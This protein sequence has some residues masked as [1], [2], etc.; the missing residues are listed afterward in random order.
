[1]S[2][3]L[4]KYLQ[5]AEQCRALELNYFDD[6]TRSTSVEPMSEDAEQI[7]DSPSYNL[8]SAKQMCMEETVS[9]V[10]IPESLEIDMGCTLCCPS[11]PC[12]DTDQKHPQSPSP[13]S[14]E[15]DTDA[16]Q[17]DEEHQVEDVAREPT[18]IHSDQLLTVLFPIDDIITPT[19]KVGCTLDTSHL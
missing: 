3:G 1:M 14:A 6:T 13:K 4:D 9:A 16:H 12:T 15:Q 18:L 17:E 10:N 2:K 5:D 8:S 7:N 11:Q 19:K